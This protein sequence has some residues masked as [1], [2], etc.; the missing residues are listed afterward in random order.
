M[1]GMNVVSQWKKSGFAVNQ[2]GASLQ[3]GMVL[4]IGSCAGGW[5]VGDGPT[6]KQDV[7]LVDGRR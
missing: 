7:K 5:N 6:G 2:I 4:R 3:G 1:A